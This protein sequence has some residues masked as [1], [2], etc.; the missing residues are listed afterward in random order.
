MFHMSYGQIMKIAWAKIWHKTTNV[1]KLTNKL[2]LYFAEHIILLIKDG[3]N[4]NSSPIEKS[5]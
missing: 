2:I 5:W 3:N 1:L 4:V